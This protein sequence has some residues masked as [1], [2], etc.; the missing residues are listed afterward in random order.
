V[1]ANKH[2]V[3]HHQ[4]AVVCGIYGHRFTAFIQAPSLL[5][6]LQA[7]AKDSPPRASLPATRYG[8]WPQ[9]ILDPKMEKWWCTWNI[10]SQLHM[11]VS[12]NGV[13]PKS[14]ILM[15]FS[16]INY[17]FWGSTIYGNPIRASKKMVMIWS[18]R[19]RSGPSRGM[20]ASTLGFTDLEKKRYP[21]SLWLCQTVCEL[22]NG[23]KNLL[24]LP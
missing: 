19:I 13:T 17:L 23:H 15:G 22:E 16:I 3:W 6:K 20:K 8:L 10:Y 12:W 2:H 21:L 9:S 1:Y 11:E 14:S 5:K 4:P 7:T 18:P 24:D